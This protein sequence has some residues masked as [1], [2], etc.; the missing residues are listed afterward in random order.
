MTSGNDPHG[1]A[2]PQEVRF[3]ILGPLEVT[4]GGRT[5]RLGGPRARGTLAALLLA[6]GRVVPTERLVDQVWGQDP[7]VSVRNQ[8][9]IAVS[10]LRR[11]LHAEGAD[12]G[13]IETV[14]AGYRLRAP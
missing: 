6:E 10:V 13:L 5:M 3:G 7:P 2:G 8:V 1:Q 11:T 4:V 14:E 12:P 9:T